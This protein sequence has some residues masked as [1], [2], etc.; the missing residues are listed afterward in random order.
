MSSLVFLGLAVVLTLCGCLFLWLRSRPPR[1]ME[2]HI[3]DFA[4]ELEALSPDKPV[5]PGPNSPPRK[6]RRSG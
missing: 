2:A 4:A 5:N 1:S 3:R 6:G